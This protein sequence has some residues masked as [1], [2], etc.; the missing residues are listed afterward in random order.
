MASFTSARNY[1]SSARSQAQDEAT[2]NLANGLHDLAQAFT[3]LESKL[4]K[5]EREVHKILSAMKRIS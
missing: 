3:N 1:F 2:R 5:S 4:E